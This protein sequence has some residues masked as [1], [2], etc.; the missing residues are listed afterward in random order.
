MENSNTRNTD[1]FSNNLVESIYCWDTDCV[2]I[3][4]AASSDMKC[5]YVQ[6]E[7]LF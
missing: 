7:N 6:F 3:L 4:V 1:Q 5:A 2:I